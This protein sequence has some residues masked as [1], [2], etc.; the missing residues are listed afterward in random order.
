M[1][2]SVLAFYGQYYIETKNDGKWIMTFDQE[3]NVWIPELQLKEGKFAW[4]WR[5]F[6]KGLYEGSLK[7]KW[8]EKG[9]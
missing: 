1:V 9:K 4:D 3:D 7:L 8:Y 5:E 6:Y 2:P